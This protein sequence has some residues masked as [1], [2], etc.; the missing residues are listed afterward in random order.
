MYLEFMKTYYN[1]L[2]I[3][4]LVLMPCLGL[5][6]PNDYIFSINNNKYSNLNKII[7]SERMFTI[8]I[9]KCISMINVLF[10]IELLLK[11]AQTNDQTLGIVMN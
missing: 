4:K 9:I 1:C 6:A 3:K 5:P 2:I 11:T 8:F 10:S 7:E